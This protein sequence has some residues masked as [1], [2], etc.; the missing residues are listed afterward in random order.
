MYT[1]SQKIT[2]TQLTVVFFFNLLY[3]YLYYLIFIFFNEYIN[4]EV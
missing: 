4:K 2:H 3:K 1:Q